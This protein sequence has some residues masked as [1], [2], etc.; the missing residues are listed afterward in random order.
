MLSPEAQVEK[1]G[2]ANPR[3][4]TK[5]KCRS[6]KTFLKVS[7]VRGWSVLQRILLASQVWDLGMPIPTSQKRRI[8]LAVHHEKLKE[9]KSQEKT[10]PG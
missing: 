6:F 1:G 9:N 4:S 10:S 8:I 3:H 7:K 2:G 5:Y